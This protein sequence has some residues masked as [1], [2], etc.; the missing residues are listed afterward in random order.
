MR[1][2]QCLGEELPPLS[3]RLA[4]AR[5]LQKDFPAG[6]ERHG[7]V[8]AVEREFAGLLANHRAGAKPGADRDLRT[9]PRP[10]CAVQTQQPG[11]VWPCR[12][13]PLWEVSGIA[14]LNAIQGE[15]GTSARYR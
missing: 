10:S 4:V 12:R 2:E 6:S 14:R 13:R 15:A 1:L 7:E 8:I 11:A 5:Q 9:P 3:T